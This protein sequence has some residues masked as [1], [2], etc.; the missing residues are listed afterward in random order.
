MRVCM[1]VCM[2]VRIPR[3]TRHTTGHGTQPEHDHRKE[4]NTEKPVY[5]CMIADNEK[6]YKKSLKKFGNIKKPP[7]LCGRNQKTKQYENNKQHHYRQSKAD[8]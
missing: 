2:I 3:V 7:Y 8:Y 1:R 4:R 5:I 6:K